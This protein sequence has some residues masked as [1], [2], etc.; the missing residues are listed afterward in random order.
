MSSEA[1]ISAS[2]LSKR[3]AIYDRPQDRLKQSLFG[4]W[5]QYYREF[6]ALKA[7]SFAIFPGEVVGIIGRNGSGKSTLLQL[8]AGTLAP[9]AGELVVNGQVAALLEFCLLYTSDAADE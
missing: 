8:I 7:L 6:W 3:Y 4:S 1:I 9:T 2:G 5:R